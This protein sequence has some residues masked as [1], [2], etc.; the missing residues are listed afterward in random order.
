VTGEGAKTS[1]VPIFVPLGFARVE[2]EVV[3]P[4]YIDVKVTYPVAEVPA[5]AAVAEEAELRCGDGS[6][7]MTKPPELPLGVATVLYDVVDPE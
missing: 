1:T 4:V 2:V 5:C 3:E 7:S 6:Y